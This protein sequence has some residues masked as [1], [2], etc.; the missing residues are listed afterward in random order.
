MSFGCAGFENGAYVVYDRRYDLIFFEVVSSKESV[1]IFD[2]G[3]QI[4]FEP[5]EPNQ[6]CGQ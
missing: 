4:C 5:I 6:D 1:G 2:L 3:S